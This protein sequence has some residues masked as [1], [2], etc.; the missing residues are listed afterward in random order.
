MYV[1]LEGERVNEDPDLSILPIRHSILFVFYVLQ[2]AFL[3]LF[4]LFFHGFIPFLFHFLESYS[5]S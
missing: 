2:F 3:P 4:F 5:F 1:T